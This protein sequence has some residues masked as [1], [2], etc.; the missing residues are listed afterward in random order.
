MFS[1]LTFYPSLVYNIVMERFTDRNWYD[2]VD[3]TA[4]LGALP[5]RS[6][7]EDLVEK[8]NVR[9]V[10]SMNEDFELLFWVPTKDEWSEKGADF[11]QLSTTDIFE[12]PTEDKLV[13]G[14]EFIKQKYLDGSSVYVHCKA[15]RTRSATLV[16]C[17]LMRRYRMKP[18]T[19]VELMRSKREHILLQAAQLEALQK[20]YDNHVQP[21]I[22]REGPAQPNTDY[23]A[24]ERAAARANQPSEGAS[25]P[26][27]EANQP[28][29]A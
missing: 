18:E 29:S 22:D 2:R 25:K 28:R 13:R 14:V 8:E 19:C 26:P 20:H 3:D 11:L 10:V 6:I 15:G 9:G 4:I 12:A 23:W 16:G 27:S 1:R 7:I 5:F 21:L 17:Y 24:P